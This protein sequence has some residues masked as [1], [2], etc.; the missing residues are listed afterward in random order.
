VSKFDSE[1]L[2]DEVLAIMNGGALNTKIVEIEAEKIAQSKG[3]TPTLKQVAAGSYHL[4]TWSEKILQSS[5]GIFYGIEDVQ[6]VENGFGLAKTYKI[7]VEVVLVDSGN[8]NDG[9]K[10]IA[11]YARALEELFQSSAAAQALNSLGCSQLKIESVRPISF[12]LELDSS[13][14][15]KV[16]GI[17]LTTTLF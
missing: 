16:G 17:S 14:E 8:S 11:R 6:S 1:N 2:L 13:E 3:L 9:S 10:R 7:F 4:Q 15:I 12:K 5:P